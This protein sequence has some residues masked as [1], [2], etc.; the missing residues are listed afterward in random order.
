[1]K[2]LEIQIETNEDTSVTFNKNHNGE[3]IIYS[4]HGDKEPT[5]KGLKEAFDILKKLEDNNV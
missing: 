4:L 1:M 3:W 2:V 5:V